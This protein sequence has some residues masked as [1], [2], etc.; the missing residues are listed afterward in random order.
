LSNIATTYLKNGSQPLAEGSDESLAIVAD[1]S[2]AT[3]E[4]SIKG[5]RSRSR[6]EKARLDAGLKAVQSAGMTPRSVRFCSDGDFEI[7]LVACAVAETDG[8]DA[9]FA[10][11]LARDS[12]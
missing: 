11:E 3:S 12:E 4:R 8:A 7:C 9:W 10:T 5:K 6:S 2:T 1:A